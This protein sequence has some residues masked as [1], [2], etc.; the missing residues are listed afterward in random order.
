MD[1]PLPATELVPVLGMNSQ[2]EG[3]RRAMREFF[4]GI[5]LMSRVRLVARARLGVGLLPLLSVPVSGVW[6]VGGKHGSTG[7]VTYAQLKLPLLVQDCCCSFWQ[8][9]MRKVLRPL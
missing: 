4:M 1:T 6:P 7:G 5:L 3:E 2:A 9:F 8:S